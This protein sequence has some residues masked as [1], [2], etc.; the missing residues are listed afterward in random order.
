[1]V[2]KFCWDA[3][4]ERYAGSPVPASESPRS[5]KQVGHTRYEGTRFWRRYRCRDCGAMRYVVGDV[6][7]GF[8][9]ERWER[10]RTIH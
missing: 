8:G 9:I 2:C 3:L 7:V 5:V 1:M 10:P 4:V 6:R